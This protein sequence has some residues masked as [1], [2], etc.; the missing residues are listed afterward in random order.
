MKK[1]KDRTISIRLDTE[2][3]RRLE[4]MAEFEERTR[5]SAALV[6]I[7]EALSKRESEFNS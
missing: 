4:E 2:T 7:K 6:L 1:L 5:S 3:L